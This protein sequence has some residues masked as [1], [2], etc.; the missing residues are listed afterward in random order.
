MD[1]PT[2]LTGTPHWCSPCEDSGAFSVIPTVSHTPKQWRSPAD[3]EHFLLNTHLQPD[4]HWHMNARPPTL[5]QKKELCIKEPR[6]TDADAGLFRQKTDLNLSELTAFLQDSF[7]FLELGGQL[8]IYGAP[9][10]K[11]VPPRQAQAQ[12][13]ALLQRTYERAS[14]FLGSY[15]LD[16]VVKKLT[17]SSKTRHID[18]IPPPDPSLLCCQNALYRWHDHQILEPCAD[19]LR[20]SHLEVCAQDIAPD[21]TPSFDDFLTT[22]TDGDADLETRILEMIGVVLTGYPSKSFFV[23]EGVSDSGKSQLAKFLKGILGETSCFAVNSINQLASRWTTGMLPG[24]LLCV[25]SDV[26]DKPLNANAVGT[27]KQLTGDDPIHGELK[28]QSP[29][30]F[31]STAKLLFLSNFP[32]RIFGSRQDDALRRRQVRI[33]FNHS[34]PLERQIPHLHR[35]LLDE[36]GGIIW[37]ALEALSDFERRN[38]IFTPLSDDAGGNTPFPLEP[39]AADCVAEFIRE[40]CKLEPSE[41]TAVHELYALYA[42]FQAQRHPTAS[43]LAPNAFGRTLLALDL[44]IEPYR[45]AETRAYRGI[46]PCRFPA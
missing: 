18:A 33:P 34:V 30:V 35:L 8:A 9:C 21:P 11:I 26:P 10:W 24:K 7:D 40:C 25:C 37:K 27:I 46:A 45:T 38:G 29:F 36:A 4:I 43:V 42:Q 44:P 17:N 14:R 12:I 31:E 20:F 23:F 41:S 19:D 16:E 5:S 39:T 3:S 28:Y 6:L 2:N 1:C 13:S 22:V 32:L 15:Q